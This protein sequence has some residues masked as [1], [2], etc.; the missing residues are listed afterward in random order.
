MTENHQ[1]TGFPPQTPVRS[2]DRWGKILPMII[3]VFVTVAVFWPVLGHQFLA[4]DNS[5]VVYK[6][7]YLQSASLDNLLHFWRYL[8][9]G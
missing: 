6:N 9:L 7:P 1:E 4:W 2:G 3:L 8:Y 5:V